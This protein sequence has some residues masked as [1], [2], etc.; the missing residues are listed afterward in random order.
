[1][2]TIFQ[3]LLTGAGV[4]CIGVGFTKVA[5]VG[6]N[7]RALAFCL[8]EDAEPQML[9][10]ILSSISFQMLA[11]DADGVNP[12]FGVCDGLDTAVESP[13]LTGQHDK[14]ELHTLSHRSHPFLEDLILHITELNVVNLWHFVRLAGKC[15]ATVF[16]LLLESLEI[17][18]EI[19]VRM[20]TLCPRGR[21]QDVGT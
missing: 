1:M 21:R 7:E 17:D 10:K 5:R 19:P 2:N 14:Q 15:D 4:P 8:N 18:F 12:Q 20:V 11:D 9:L 6:K 16:Y 3:I 13:I